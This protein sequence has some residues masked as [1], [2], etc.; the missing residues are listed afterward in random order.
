MG[1][2]VNAVLTI[3][4]IKWGFSALNPS[5]VQNGQIGQ[6]AQ[7]APDELMGICQFWCVNASQFVL[8]H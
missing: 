7:N 6:A 5:G 3:N 2:G 1:K 8:T 4:A